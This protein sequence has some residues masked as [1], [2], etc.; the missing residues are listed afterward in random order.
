MSD[1]L[2]NMVFNN[3]AQEKNGTIYI[4]TEGNG[5]YKTNNPIVSVQQPVSMPAE[6][7]LGQAYPNPVQASLAAATIP[8]SLVRQT[9][10]DIII[11]NLHG[12][13]VATLHNGILQ[14][15]THNFTL[16]AQAIP[17]GVYSVSLRTRNSIQSHNII[18]MK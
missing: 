2:D 8:V 3:I 1:G 14:A 17:P 9:H 12:Q 5:I 7:R 6:I 16:D 10:V 15:G 13:R 18:I 4:G 11:Y